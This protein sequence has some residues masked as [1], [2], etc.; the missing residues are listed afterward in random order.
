MKPFIYF[1]KYHISFELKFSLIVI[2]NNKALQIKLGWICQ[3]HF[4]KDH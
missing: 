3:I 2:C 4:W 1:I